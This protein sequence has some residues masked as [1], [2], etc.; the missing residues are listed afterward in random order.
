MERKI[1]KTFPVMC[2]GKLITVEVTEE[3]TCEG[4]AF[5]YLSCVNDPEVLKEIGQCSSAA[6]KDKTSVVFKECKA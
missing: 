6:R 5:E 1:G 4:C 3:A 2:K